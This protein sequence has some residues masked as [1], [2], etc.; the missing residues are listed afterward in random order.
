MLLVKMLGVLFTHTYN[1]TSDLDAVN[2]IW[3]L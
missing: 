3:V 1:I 2:D